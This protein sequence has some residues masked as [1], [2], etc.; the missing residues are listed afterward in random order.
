MI[1]KLK[2]WFHDLTGS[3]DIKIIV[4]AIVYYL[5]A[6]L[7]LLLAFEGTSISPVWPPSGIALALLILL[8]RKSWPGIL[9]GALVANA[10]VFWPG[11]GHNISEFI[12]ATTV[13]AVACALEAL[14]GRFLVTRWLP[15]KDCFSRTNHTFRFII[16]ALLI[17]WI[18]PVMGFSALHLSGSLTLDQISSVGFTWYVGDLTGILIFT[19]MILVWRGRF[20]LALTKAKVLESFIFM[21]FLA[22]LIILLDLEPISLII[23]RAFPFLVVPFLLWM[24]F[25]FNLQLAMT[26][27]VMASLTAVIFTINERGPFLLETENDSLL[28]LQ[29]FMGIISV[30]TLIISSTVRERKEAQS[31]I[32]KFNESLEEK[33]RARTS[34][35]EKEIDER[36]KAE[37][38]IKVSNK[39][40]QKT[41]GELD[42][43]VYSVSH[44]LRA[45]IASV[46]GLLNLIKNEKD[47]QSVNNYLAMIEKRIDQQDMFIKDILDLSRNARQSLQRDAVQ[48]SELID[49]VFSQLQFFNQSD[50]IQKKIEI[51]QNEPFVTDR[52]RV[53]VIL[54]NLLSNAIRYSNGKDPVIEVS[55]KVQKRSATL[56][57]KDNGIGIGEEHLSHVFDMFYR[58]TDHNTGSGLGLYIVKETLEKLNGEVQ[59]Q[60]EIG[61]GTEFI[62]AIPILRHSRKKG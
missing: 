29:V 49:E 10:F 44:D 33:V 39:K 45:P 51:D 13:I 46:K 4:A 28:L 36:K 14:V 31:T 12:T 26:G 6:R 40:L 37:N 2:K 30:T 34:A 47:I 62:V 32:E 58:A 61:Q 55:V 42:S 7:G 15:P 8:G 41:N 50:S 17:S 18:T 60:S 43:F 11:H 3:L 24:A 19:P 5:S 48:F 54:N 23:E 53:R 57:V 9:I 35:L 52:R 16:I 1:S 21:A 38:R 27:I 22:G 25:S 56:R 59:V 20:D